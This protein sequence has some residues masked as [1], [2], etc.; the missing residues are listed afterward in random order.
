MDK[1]KGLTTEQVKKLRGQYG[2]NEIKDIGRATPLMIFIRQIKQNFIIYLLFA[3]MILSFVVGKD[4]TAFTI[5]G[6][7]LVV[8]FSGFIQEYKAEKSIESLKNMIMPV[9]RVIRNGEEVEIY[10]T[11]IVP[12]DILILG[13][14]E[15]VPSD[16]IVLDEREL[17]VDESTLTGES[18]EIKKTSK[19][20]K[21][22]D[23]NKLFMG[24]FIVNGRC[25]ARAEHIGMNTRFGKIAAMI[26]TTEKE[27]PLQSKVNSISKYMVLIAIIASTSTA[28]LLILSADAIN[29]E[30]LTNVL[31]L[32][33]ALSVSAFPEGFPVVMTTTLATGVARM[34]KKNAIVNRMSIIE[35]LGETTVICT[36]KTGTVTKGEMTVNTIYTN[37]KN[38]QV[39]GSGYM[40]T[41]DFTSEGNNINPAENPALNLIIKSSV[42]CND[43]RIQRTGEDN[44]YKVVGTPTEGALL[45][46]A[47]KAEI[48]PEDMD[49][50]RHFEIPFSSERKLMSVLSKEDEG[51]FVYVKGAP[52]VLLPKCTKIYKNSEHREISEDDKD[53][54]LEKNKQMNSESLRTL[55]LAYK[56]YTESDK[57]YNEDNLVFLGLVG[58]EDPPRDE[59][60]EAL[61]DCTS[62]GIGV[63]MIT[64]DNKETAMSISK[65]IG[66]EGKMLEGW[67]LDELSDAELVPIAKET[68]IFARVRPEH[69]LRIVRALKESGEIVTM[70]GDGVNDAPALKEAHIGVA[71]GKNGTDVT[72]SVSD[73]ILKDDNFST[74]VLA[75]KEGRTIFSNIR[76]F[77]SYQLSDNAA[78]LFVIFLGVVLA[79]VLG[80]HTPLLLA[81]QI[82]FM[83]LVTDSLPAITLGLNPHSKDVMQDKPRRDPSILSKPLLKLVLFNGSLMGTMTLIT[84][85]I[86]FNILGQSVEVAR[87]TALA[88]LIILEIASAFNFRSFRKPTL[89]RSPFVNPYLVYA[90]VIS[91]AA[92]LVIVY[93]HA[94]QAIFET[95]PLGLTQWVA[96][97]GAGLLILVVFDFLK[98]FSKRRGILFAKIV[99]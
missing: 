98:A 75:V 85:F 72:R 79:P 44:E 67:Q 12:G 13:N 88:T 6:V 78:E 8:I 92:T 69:K 30:L 51:F 46:M 81:L 99:N 50:E 53:E 32:A 93:T 87:T 83:N 82:L 94:G 15:R 58:M 25:L 64:G 10:S 36:D 11:E 63:K 76:K 5:L 41:G 4:I 49:A 62:A 20:I 97:I 17:R 59:I 45:I 24:T 7:I 66:L 16:A 14:G 52:E 57:K 39:S 2:S 48:F 47:A 27:M 90:S 33:I 80:W 29:Y 34:A 89:S 22:S 56:P 35:T 23:E 86:S 9:S 40:A 91:V 1:Y 60:Q 65:Q 71:M 31:I 19:K 55:A 43:S 54:I 3:A 42:L 73:L 37:Y 77:V 18:A 95:V 38:Y 28:V 74:I 84:Y 96:A 21:G 70:T 61:A 26:S 68:T